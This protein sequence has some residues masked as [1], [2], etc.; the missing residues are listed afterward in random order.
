M[1]KLILN[2]VLYVHVKDVLL[3][4]VNDWVLLYL[5]LL[6]QSQIHF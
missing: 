6:I 1:K 3:F 5:F 4:Y 2:S